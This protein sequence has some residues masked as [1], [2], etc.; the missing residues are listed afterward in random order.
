MNMLPIIQI[1]G[2]QFMK[3]MG[4]ALEKLKTDPLRSVGFRFNLYPDG[5]GLPPEFLRG[6][7][8]V[9]VKIKYV[10][11][12]EFAT[13]E[14]S[15]ICIDAP[16]PDS[17]DKALWGTVLACC[18]GGIPFAPGFPAWFT[19]KVM[20][21]STTDRLALSSLTTRR[22]TLIGLGR[23]VTEALAERERAAA[24]L[25]R[26]GVEPVQSLVISFPT[27]MQPVPEGGSLCSPSPNSPT[28]T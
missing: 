11:Q 25:T 16:N 17:A 20:A 12:P 15:V 26:A 8:G 27:G 21:Y 10:D 4:Q 19:P 22:L 14:V 23:T 2:R 13:E 28:P 18:S 1:L 5:A 7:I 3:G 9:F 24:T 6:R